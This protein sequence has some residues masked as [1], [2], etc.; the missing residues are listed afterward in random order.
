MNCKSCN[1]TIPTSQN[2]CPACGRAAPAIDLGAPQPASS[3]SGIHP[4]LADSTLKPLAPTKQPSTPKGVKSKKSKGK[5]ASSDLGKDRG[6]S[7][8]SQAAAKAEAQSKP[9]ESTGW[10]LFSLDPGE[11]RTLLG[12][13]P[14]LL[15]AGLTVACGE[16]GQPVG[17][18]YQT[19]VGEI[20]LLAVDE[21]G[22]LVVVTVADRE[23]DARLIADVL[24]RI[25]WV[26]T[27]LEKE[28][29]PVRAIVLTEPLSEELRYAAAAVS[30][31]VNFKTYRVS[32]SFDDLKLS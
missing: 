25:G 14:E 31:T 3:S 6:K 10:S 18:R 5:G 17:H 28:G 8:A 23:S 24:Q 19:E 9:T 13:Q 21:A 1:T 29:A 20:D 22:A 7:V 30:S 11:L 32:L 12:E 15:E 16:A 26:R 2:S 4:P 27:H